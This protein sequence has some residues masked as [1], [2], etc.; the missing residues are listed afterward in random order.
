M[1]KF[2]Y[3]PRLN[4][5]LKDGMILHYLYPGQPKDIEIDDTLTSNYPL[6]Y[7]WYPEDASR[8]SHG[9]IFFDGIKDNHGAKY[10]AGYYYPL[11]EGSDE[12]II[13]QLHAIVKDIHYRHSEGGTLYTKEKKPKIEEGSTEEYADE[14]FSWIV[15]DDNIAILVNEIRDRVKVLKEKGVAEKIIITATQRKTKIESTCHY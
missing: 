13:E 1:Y 10:I 12:Y 7:L 9:M 3:L 15:N 4:E 14:L 6:K 5:D 11:E 2:V 8:I